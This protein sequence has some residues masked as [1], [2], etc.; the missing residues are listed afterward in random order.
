MNARM[1]RTKT[2]AVRPLALLVSLMALL[3]GCSGGTSSGITDSRTTKP[4]SANTILTQVRAAGQIGNEL[5]VQPLRDPQVEDLRV[6][7]TQAE[8]RADFVS[9]KRA[10]SQ[11]LLLTPNDPDLLQWQA[12]LALATREWAQ[13]E[14]L[15]SRSYDKGPKLGG[16][17][18]RNW[19]TIRFAAEARGNAAA[20]AQ[21]QQRLAACTV[22]PP[23]RM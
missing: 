15:A 16:L 23:I 14:L 12:E 6:A 8:R 9:A 11:A 4:G 19:T 7:A 22:A 18:R 5:D 20:G 1:L 10:I 17:C 3:A 13:A 2:S 21:A